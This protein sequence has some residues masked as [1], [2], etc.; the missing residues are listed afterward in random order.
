MKARGR[1]SAGAI[2]ASRAQLTHLDARANTNGTDRVPH[3]GGPRK[4]SQTNSNSPNSMSHEESTETFVFI[5]LGT[6]F[7]LMFSNNASAGMTRSVED[8]REQQN[9]TPCGRV[10][11]TGTCLSNMISMV[12]VALLTRCGIGVL[13]VSCF[14][15]SA[16]SDRPPRVPPWYHT[17]MTDLHGLAAIALES[18]VP[19]P[20]VP[21]VADRF[22]HTVS[23]YHPP[24]T[25]VSTRPPTPEW[26]DHQRRTW[27]CRH[28]DAPAV[29]R[30][31][32]Q[33]PHLWSDEQRS[34][35]ARYWSPG[36]KDD[37]K[38]PVRRLDGVRRPSSA[39]HHTKE[40]HEEVSRVRAEYASRAHS[41]G[42]RRPDVERVCSGG[43][44]RADFDLLSL[45]LLCSPF[46]LRRRQLATVA[47]ALRSKQ[48]YVLSDVVLSVLPDIEPLAFGPAMFQ[49]YSLLD[50]SN[51]TDDDQDHSGFQMIVGARGSYTSPHFDFFGMD[52]YLHLV[53][54]EK[55]WWIAPPESEVAF[56][57]LFEREGTNVGVTKAK[58]DRTRRLAAIQAVAI[59][60]RPGDLVFVPG[61]WVHCVK[62]LTSTVGFGGAY[63]RAWK[64]TTTMVYLPGTSEDTSRILNWK[65]AFQRAYDEPTKYGITPEEAES[66]KRTEE[67]NRDYYHA[68]PAS[69]A[70]HDKC[71]M[72]SLFRK[73][74]GRR[75]KTVGKSKSKSILPT[76]STRE[77]RRQLQPPVD[78]APLTKK[79]RL[80]E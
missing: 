36:W 47:M 17:T 73:R 45:L 37:P 22:L 40:L 52:G 63:L 1:P 28:R 59:H 49:S 51:E 77:K 16:M 64:L 70:D 10:M 9:V 55:L 76:T 65:A 72:E 50:R 42:V 78:D 30:N 8:A 19:P 74:L 6:F 62:N 21:R 68:Y 69:D 27:W 3:R 35:I 38:S 67:L 46:S 57:K 11:H 2:I 18:P 29:F 24:S 71:S 58:K 4:H 60:Q 15:R 20:I 39:H 31:A 53:E 25:T 80:A 13:C 66:I 54:G 56:R 44:P 14:F 79:R 34:L 26:I 5:T 43:R 61:G 12:E 48:S 7:D 41:V 23:E 75:P 33:H 32:T